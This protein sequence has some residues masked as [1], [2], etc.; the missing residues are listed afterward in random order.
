MNEWELAHAHAF[1]RGMRL[2]TVR[3]QLSSPSGLVITP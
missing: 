1:V 3:L 2:A